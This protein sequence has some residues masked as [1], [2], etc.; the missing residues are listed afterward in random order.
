M[1]AVRHAGDS[2]A[3]LL[4]RH[5]KAALVPGSTLE[6]FAVKSAR[7][8]ERIAARCSSVGCCAASVPEMPMRSN[9]ASS[10]DLNMGE[11]LTTLA[12][13][14]ERPRQCTHGPL[15]SRAALRAAATCV[16]RNLSRR[17]R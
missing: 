12:T 7:Q 15:A 2:F 16:L 1:T 11:T 10:D 3:S 14:V 13:E 6:Q 8:A 5:I 17:L 9:A 4:T